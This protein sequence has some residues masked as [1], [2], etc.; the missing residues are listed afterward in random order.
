[1]KHDFRIEPLGIFFTDSFHGPIHWLKYLSAQALAYVA[2]C[3]ALGKADYDIY[4]LIS[5]CNITCQHVNP[6]AFII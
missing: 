1:M 6:Q 5:Q 2:L 4:I 3:D